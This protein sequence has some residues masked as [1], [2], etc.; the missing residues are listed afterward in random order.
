MQHRKHRTYCFKTIEN[1]SY[2]QAICASDADEA[3]FRASAATAKVGLSC[4]HSV[5]R[6]HVVIGENKRVSVRLTS[7]G[8]LL[9]Y[10]A[11]LWACAAL[12][13]H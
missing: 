6:A 3:T 10:I 4:M 2:S 5:K 11:G 9:K 12:D 7:E 13:S 1:R 8:S